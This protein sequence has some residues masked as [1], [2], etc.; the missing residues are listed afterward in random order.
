MSRSNNDPKWHCEQCGKGVM[1]EYNTEH[2]CDYCETEFC[3]DCGEPGSY[4]CY[5]CQN[6]KDFWMK[7]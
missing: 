4:I 7:K 2:W 1:T 3:S 6:D 5:G